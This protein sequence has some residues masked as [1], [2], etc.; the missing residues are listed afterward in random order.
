MGPSFWLF[1]LVT[2]Y[3]L[4]QRVVLGI[5]MDK[6]PFGESPCCTCSV[7]ARCRGPLL[8]KGEACWG[9]ELRVGTCCCNVELGPGKNALV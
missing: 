7:M 3:V 9:S 2:P 4:V 1:S 8:P 6:L 5:F